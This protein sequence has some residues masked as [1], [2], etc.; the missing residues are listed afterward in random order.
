MKTIEIFKAGTRRDANG[1]VVTITTDD[2]KA[3]AANYSPEFHEAPLVVGH[4]KHDNP[5]YGWVKSLHV[6]GDVLKA[7]PTQVDA[8]FAELVSE[9][10]YKKISAAFYMPTASANP[11]TGQFYLRHVG[12][13]GAMP[14]AVKGLR[15]PEFNENEDDVI[16]FTEDFGTENTVVVEKNQS[17]TNPSEDK[18][19]TDPVQQQPSTTGETMD[20]EK[21]IEQL[22]A[23]NAR[24]QASIAAKEK[25]AAEKENAAFAEGLVAEGKL[26][27]AQKDAVL[28]L[29]NADMQSAEFAE[30]GFKDQLKGFLSGLP[31]VV[32][33]EE[34][35]TADKVAAAT[36]ES[37]EYAEGTDPASIEADQK[38][39]AYMSEHKV[40]Y[41]TAFN[42][43]YQ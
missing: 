21:E 5:A 12:F 31:K 36:G 1:Q 25:E 17:G 15:N 41:A 40:D 7:E 10:K 37:V 43:I 13:L 8:Q 42:A 35:A 4:P 34:V 33:T 39:R 19:T 24:L 18:T 38:I 20:K 27:P 30:T 29:L 32:T 16:E 11:R 23:E 6:D 26:A 3:V 14:P 28:S 2:L 22:K 9:G